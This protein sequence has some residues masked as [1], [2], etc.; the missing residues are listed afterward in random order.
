MWYINLII[1]YLVTMSVYTNLTCPIWFRFHDTWRH[2]ATTSDVLYW[3]SFTILKSLNQ[4]SNS[5]SDKIL[6]LRFGI[7]TVTCYTVCKPIKIAQ[8]IT[9]CFCD[10]CETLAGIILQKTPPASRQALWKN[11][12]KRSCN[13]TLFLGEGWVGQNT[14]QKYRVIKLWYYRDILKN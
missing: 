9:Q 5:G 7:L 10:F 14:L 11:W 8:T 12:E 2:Q 1:N 3:N 13:N 6:H 4:E